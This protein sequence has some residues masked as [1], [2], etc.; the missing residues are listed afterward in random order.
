MSNPH[1][2]QVWDAEFRARMPKAYLSLVLS[3][4]DQ[5][6][7]DRRCVNA[8]GCTGSTTYWRSKHCECFQD[9]ERLVNKG[10]SENAH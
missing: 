6:I 10:E 3:A 2:A 8:A 5:I 9:A 1:T 7:M 4:Y